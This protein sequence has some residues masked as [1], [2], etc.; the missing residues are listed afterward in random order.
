MGAKKDSGRLNRSLTFTVSILLVIN[1]VKNVFLRELDGGG[2]NY[3]WAEDL[4]HSNPLCMPKGDFHFKME[5]Y[6]FYLREHLLAYGVTPTI[7]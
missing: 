4:S 7:N 5:W 6:A 3:A 2:G 1:V